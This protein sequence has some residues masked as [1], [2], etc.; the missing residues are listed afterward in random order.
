LLNHFAF[1]KESFKETEP[2]KKGEEGVEEREKTEEA[3][4]TKVE[5]LALSSRTINVLLKNNI[6]T[7]EGLARKSEASLVELEGMGE[8]GVKEIKK[9]LK[10]VDLELKEEKK[11]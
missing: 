1:F 5:D 2:Q 3:V 7:A 4:K 8:K 10:K 9:A 6:K 11:P